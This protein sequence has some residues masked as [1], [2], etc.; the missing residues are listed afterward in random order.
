MT[1]HNYIFFDSNIWKLHPG[2]LPVKPNAGDFNYNKTGY[3][4]A[5]EDYNQA[6]ADIKS[7]AL[8]V[9]NPEIMELVPNGNDVWVDHILLHYWPGSYEKK[10]IMSEGWQPTY[11]N[12]DNHNLDPP[13]EPKEAVHLVLPEGKTKFTFCDTS[14]RMYEN[15]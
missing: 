5:L 3:E 2:E 14:M 1:E 8:V 10:M 11:N 7:K 4:D 13:A 9:E 15:R 6:I 12:P